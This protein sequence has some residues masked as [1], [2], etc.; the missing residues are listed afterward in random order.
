MASVKDMINKCRNNVTKEIIRDLVRE[1]DYSLNEEMD[2]L[3]RGSYDNGSWLSLCRI[4]ECIVES[5]N[6]Y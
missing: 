1:Y 6:N 3:D 4:I 5:D 2:Y